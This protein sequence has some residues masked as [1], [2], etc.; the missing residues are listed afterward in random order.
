MSDPDL[1]HS[2]IPV[3][4]RMQRLIDAWQARNDRRAAFLACYQMMTANMLSAI[5]RGEFHD[6]NWVNALLHRFAGYYFNALDFYEA[7]DPATPAVWRIT[8]DVSD[9]PRVLILQN[10]LLGM[11]AHINYDLVF[12]LVDLLEPEWARLTPGERQRRY[13]DHSHVN[14]VIQRTIDVVQDTIIEPDAPLMQ[15]ADIL[16]GRADEWLV[17]RMIGNWREEVWAHAQ[18]LLHAADPETRQCLTRE[19]EQEAL[20]RANLILRF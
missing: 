5:D 7:N 11:N 9:Q 10:L 15:L 6:P 4:E 14:A 18:S 1:I 20:K 17:S 12:T 3:T 16:L 8:F 13:A 19:I 2:P